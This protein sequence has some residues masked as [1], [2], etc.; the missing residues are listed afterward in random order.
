MQVKDTNRNKR[1][2]GWLALACLVLQLAVAPN[3]GIGNGRIDFALVFSAIVALSIGGR[4]GVACGFLAGLVFDLSGTGPVGLM[5]LLLSVSSFLMG[6]ECRNRLSE[7]FAP[8]VVLFAIHA[9]AVT[10]VYHLAM[11]LVGEA[12][13]V[14]DVLVLRTLPT[15]LLTLFVFVPFAYLWSRGRGGGPTLG[16]RGLTVGDAP[17][18]PHRG[19]GGRYNIGRRG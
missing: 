17:R 9:L 11:F 5:S 6:S 8:S 4:T 3:F 2:I 18:P 12:S 15:F 14:F 10:L 19:R 1:S 7:D 13:S 16:G